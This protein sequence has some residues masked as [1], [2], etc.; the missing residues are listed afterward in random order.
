M[1]AVIFAK[2]QQSAGDKLEKALQSRA[3][4][5]T[6]FFPFLSFPFRVR[7]ELTSVGVNTV[8]GDVY[9]SV[10]CGV[11]LLFALRNLVLRL[12][13]WRARRRQSRLEQQ[14]E[15]GSTGAAVVVKPALLRWSDRVDRA[16]LRP[17]GV[18][19]FE[20]D[21]EMTWLRLG[22]V[23]GIVVVSFF[24]SVYIRNEEEC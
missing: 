13:R 22:L 19:P 20:K 24:D 5:R 23:M 18:W 21:P 7:A 11:I 10:V 12:A 6:M 8:V 16:M 1:P 14:R 3:S 9:S 15:K 4:L 17:V 2:K